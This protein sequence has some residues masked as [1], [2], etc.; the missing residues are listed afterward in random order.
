MCWIPTS[1]CWGVECPTSRGCTL[2]CRAFG[3]SMCFRTM[4]RPAW[5]AM[6]TAIPAE[7]AALLGCGTKGEGRMKYQ[8]LAAVVAAVFALPAA[9][10][11]E[12]IKFPND[13]LRGV[14]YQ[15]VDRADV[16]QYRELYTQ[17]EV[18]DAVR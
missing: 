7:C 5:C 9:A 1:S 4:W 11:P 13:Y 14:L 6:P 3:R 17:A 18:V 2:K 10:G 12:K 16:K 15:S 8:I